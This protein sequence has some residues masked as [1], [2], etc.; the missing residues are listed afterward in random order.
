MEPLSIPD[1]ALYFYSK[2]PDVDLFF[3]HK[4]KEFSMLFVKY[5]M[6]PQNLDPNNGNDCLQVLSAQLIWKALQEEPTPKFIRTEISSIDQKTFASLHAWYFQTLIWICKL[7]VNDCNL[8]REL[9]LFMRLKEGG[10]IDTSA[11]DK[12]VRSSIDVCNAGTHNSIDSSF[13]NQMNAR[14]KINR[15]YGDWSEYNPAPAKL[16][17]QIEICSQLLVHAIV[18][19]NTA[20][21]KK[22]S[23]NLANLSEKSYT[24]FGI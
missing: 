16:S 4:A 22:H 3:K 15:D 13:I 24:E 9:V 2:N 6:I 19:G 7:S 18:N 10:L 20:A 1:L 5:V 12:L 11:A 8:L 14:L 17:E 23:V 21:I